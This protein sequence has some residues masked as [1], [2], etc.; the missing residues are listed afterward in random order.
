VIMRRAEKTGECHPAE[1]L[2]HGTKTWEWHRSD[3]KTFLICTAPMEEFVSGNACTMTIVRIFQWTLFRFSQEGVLDTLFDWLST[4]TTVVWCYQKVIFVSHPCHRPDQATSD[5]RL[6]R[7]IKRGIAGS[8]VSV[9]DSLMDDIR[10]FLEAIPAEEL[11]CVLQCWIERW[12]WIIWHDWTWSRE[13]TMMSEVTLSHSPP[14]DLP[15][16]HSD[17]R[18]SSREL[19]STQLT[20]LHRLHGILP[21]T[22]L[23]GHAILNWLSPKGSV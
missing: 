20:N 19:P 4:W 5:F 21:R 15:S 16:Q 11:S 9:F 12:T 3:T 6:F 1:E 22:S 8:D 17:A 2:L 10:T 23:S 13:Q 18:S 7:R 14:I